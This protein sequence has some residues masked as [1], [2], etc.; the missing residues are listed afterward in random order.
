MPIQKYV[1][2]N[3]REDTKNPQVDTQSAQSAAQ[4]SSDV[5]NDFAPCKDMMNI[6]KNI[7]NI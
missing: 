6:R 3:T 1:S 4:R 7:A 2:K 5:G